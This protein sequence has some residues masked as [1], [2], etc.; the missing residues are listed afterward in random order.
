M[1]RIGLVTIRRHDKE[2]DEGKCPLKD[3]TECYQGNH[4]IDECGDD[5]EEN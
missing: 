2:Y 3:E 4:D 1:S 5:V